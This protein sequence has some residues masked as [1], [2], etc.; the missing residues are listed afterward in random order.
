M[1]IS[2][3]L[4]LIPCRLIHFQLIDESDFEKLASILNLN[5][6]ET[7]KHSI[8][9]FDFFYKKFKNDPSVLNWWIYFIVLQSEKTI[10]GSCGFKGKPDINGEVEIGYEILK[11]YRNQ[12]YASETAATLIKFAFENPEVKKIKASTYSLENASVHVLKNQ[13]MFF[14]THSYN[15]LEGDLWHWA[16]KR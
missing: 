5:L 12:G 2:G 10:I 16:I 15:S 8:D 14:E 11:E 3:R 6:K 4:H 7:W 13:K 9:H 1:L